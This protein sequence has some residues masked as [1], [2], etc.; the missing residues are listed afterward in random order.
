MKARRVAVFGAGPGGLT[1]A[2]ELAERGFKVDV[3]ERLDRLG[4]M[5]RSFVTPDG[6]TSGRPSL[7]TTCGGHFFLPGYANSQDMLMRIPTATGG[8]VIDRLTVPTQVTLAIPS[9]VDGAAI[10]LHIPT[11][12]HHIADLSLDQ[13]LR[14]VTGTSRLVGELKASDALLLASK[15]AAWISSGP[16]RQAGQLEHI[17][18]EHGFFRSEL[19]SST[20]HTLVRDLATTISWDSPSSGVSAAAYVNFIVDPIMH[21]L[22][23]RPA[24]PSPPQTIAKVLDGPETEVW[25]DPWAR[26]LRGLGVTFHTRHTLTSVGM[27]SG[28]IAGVTVQEQAG[29]SKNVDADWYVLAMPTDRLLALLSEEILAVDQGLTDVRRLELSTESGFEVFFR[30]P[31]GFTTGQVTNKN[32]T[33]NW[34]LT[35]VGLSDIW[36]LNLS[37][38]GDGNV[39]GMMSVEFNN[40]PYFDSPGVLFGK[41]IRQLTYNQAFEEVRAHI[42]QGFPDGAQL[43][44]QDNLV[45]WRPH[46]TLTWS[47]GSGWT[48]PDKRTASAPGTSEYFPDQVRKAPNLFLAG[49]HTKNSTGGD[50]MESAVESG[51][52]AANAIVEAAGAHERPVTIHQYGPPPELQAV[53]DAD[54]HRFRAGLPNVFDLVAPARTPIDR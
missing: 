38:F 54:D 13:L 1:A 34:L 51:K 28:R 42:V 36:E 45:G 29:R 32:V 3:Y 50:S 46:P 49:G 20:A 47:K 8:T 26:Y 23:G 2:H 53:R 16:E 44:A 6:G 15:F 9:V 43:F 31:L 37:D 11:S 4:G 39:R 17:D 18:L 35:L 7:P 19:L 40:H 5:V 25:F 27:E 52:I 22:Y 14:T 10:A 33:D 21:A 30:D 12:R 48:V 24:F 41:P